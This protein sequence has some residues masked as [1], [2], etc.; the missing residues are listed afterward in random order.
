MFDRSRSREERE[1]EVENGW[2]E[3]FEEITMLRKKL[4]E[5]GNISL[6]ISFND[7]ADSIKNDH[8]RSQAEYFSNIQALDKEDKDKKGHWYISNTKDTRE[9]TFLTRFEAA[10]QISCARLVALRSLAGNGRYNS[11]K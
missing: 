11:K 1:L 7:I 10:L 4:K 5:Q 6:M 2:R 8:V 9:D 3:C